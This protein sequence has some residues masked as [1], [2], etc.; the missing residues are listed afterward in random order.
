MSDI[1]RE[2]MEV[3]VQKN[4]AEFVENFQRTEQEAN[5]MLVQRFERD[6]EIIAKIANLNPRDWTLADTLMIRAVLFGMCGFLQEE[7]R[8]K[9]NGN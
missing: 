6:I 7:G 9:R 2:V 5:D 1:E 3:I 4:I 8:I